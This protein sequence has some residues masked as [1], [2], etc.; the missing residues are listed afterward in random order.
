MA[1]YVSAVDDLPLGDAAQADALVK[2]ITIGDG[3]QEQIIHRAMQKFIAEREKPTGA[4]RP[5]VS[6]EAVEA[7]LAALKGDGQA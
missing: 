4:L 6:R 7:V 5:D 1:R 3:A 2:H